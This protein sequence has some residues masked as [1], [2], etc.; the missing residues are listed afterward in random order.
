MGT[1]KMVEV[2]PMDNVRRYPPKHKPGE[3]GGVP[4]VASS[5]K[6]L[7]L[8]RLIHPSSNSLCGK[9]TERTSIFL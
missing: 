4:P 6:K 8:A 2:E 7:R 9:Y 1:R 5:P 3:G